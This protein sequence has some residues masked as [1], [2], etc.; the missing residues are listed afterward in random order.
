MSNKFLLGV[1]DLIWKAIN[2]RFLLT[3]Y[4]IDNLFVSH[5]AIFIE[6][7]PLVETSPTIYRTIILN[8]VFGIRIIFF[9]NEAATRNNLSPLNQLIIHIA[10]IA[11]YEIIVSKHD[12]EG[13]VLGITDNF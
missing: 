11:R 4:L 8:K 5:A 6:P 10:S 2:L 3:I 13:L 9:L 12:S 1:E 7:S